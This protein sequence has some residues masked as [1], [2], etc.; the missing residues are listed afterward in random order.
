MKKLF[1]AIWLLVFTCT[2]APAGPDNGKNEPGGIG[3]PAFCTEVSQGKKLRISLIQGEDKD[4][5][6]RYG[7]ELK[8]AIGGVDI[9]PP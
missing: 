6:T 2:S 3:K 9:I 8:T 1:W 5:V 4:A 7:I